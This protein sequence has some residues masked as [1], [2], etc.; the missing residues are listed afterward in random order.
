MYPDPF[1]FP[2]RTDYLEKHDNM[3]TANITGLN[4]LT[5]R[6]ETPDDIR[7]ASDKPNNVNLTT[8]GFYQDFKP[9]YK[10]HQAVNDDPNIEESYPDIKIIDDNTGKPVQIP[11]VTR[12]KDAKLHN[13]YAKC[14]GIWN[15]FPVDPFKLAFGN[16]F[17]QDDDKLCFHRI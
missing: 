16:D 14:H 10:I 11:V 6:M 17:G 12:N 8:F 3:V 15:L 7:G 9:V 5:N 4:Y 2:W 1:R 13:N